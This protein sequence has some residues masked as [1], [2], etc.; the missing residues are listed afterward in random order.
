MV[1]QEY[2]Y[3]GDLTGWYQRLPKIELHVHLEGS[4]PLKA[5]WQLMRKYGGNLD[6]PDLPALKE[7]FKFRDFAHF[8]ELWIWKNGF[9]REY[10][11]FTFFL[12][13]S[14]GTWLTRT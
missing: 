2:D 11:D 7:R 6:V 5:L 8:I 12:K 1:N 13:P 4:I 14:P 9:L 10:E 3:S